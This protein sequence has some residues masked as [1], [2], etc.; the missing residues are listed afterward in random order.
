MYQTQIDIDTEWLAYGNN[1][2][3]RIIEHAM[4]HSLRLMARTNLESV[5]EARFQM[6]RW[7]CSY[8]RWHNAHWARFLRWLGSRVRL[9]EPLEILVGMEWW[10]H[11]YH[12]VTWPE[13]MLDKIRIQMAYL[14]KTDQ[15][16]VAICCGPQGAH[17][18][19]GKGYAYNQY[20]MA[21]DFT[22][23]GIELFGLPVRVIPWLD[24]NEVMVV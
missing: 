4:S 6:G 17:D 22:A 8:P 18:L 1:I 20:R 23:A 15:S 12:T 5:R 2:R 21:T 16:P 24:R 13:E 11:D 9:P 7:V 10:T 19:Q 14:E 3:F